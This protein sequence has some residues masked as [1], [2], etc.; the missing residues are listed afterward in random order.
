MG[1]M[2]SSSWKV[3]CGIFVFLAAIMVILPGCGGRD[4]PSDEEAIIRKFSQMYYKSDA[5]VRSKWMGIRTEQN[6]CDMWMIQEIISTTKP[7]FIVETGTLEGGS[8]LF[9]AMMLA[10]VNENGRVISVD[11]D[12]RIERASQFQ[13]FKER[14]EVIK[15][16]SV[17]PEVINQIAERVRGHRVLVTL[18][19]DHSKDHV[20]KELH[21]YSKFVSKN[22]YLIVQDTNI[23]GH[24]VSPE[25]GPGPREAVEEF[26]ASN[27][28]FIVDKDMERHMLT[29]YPSGYL[30]RVR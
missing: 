14:V 25:H 9:F 11:I 13:A 7:D 17:S 29:F 1:N 18:D 12:P 28:D 2:S 30:K 8:T 23:N 19:S 3:V 22:G 15:G 6:P 27:K 26:L 21:L 20:L 24:P 10:Q 4:T 5:W 16:D